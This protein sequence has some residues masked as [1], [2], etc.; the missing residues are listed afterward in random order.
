[1]TQIK[2]QLS[3]TAKRCNADVSQKMLVTL[4][5][6]LALLR[7]FTVQVDVIYSS[8]QGMI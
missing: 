3:G 5:M 6:V 4:Q 7:L 1:M 2:T 8:S